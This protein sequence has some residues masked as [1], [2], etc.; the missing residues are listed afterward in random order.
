MFMV[1]LP[2][3]ALMFVIETPFMWLVVGLIIYAVNSSG[4]IDAGNH[5]KNENNQTS[6]TK[7]QW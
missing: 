1:L 3:M 5:P 4:T 7:E 2:F 6:I